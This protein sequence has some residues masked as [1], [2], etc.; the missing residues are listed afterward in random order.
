VA[1]EERGLGKEAVAFFTFAADAVSNAAW[2]RALATEGDALSFG[3]D[4]ALLPVVRA[5][6]EV[7]FAAG[8]LEWPVAGALAGVVV[9]E[10][11]WVATVPMASLSSPNSFHSSTCSR[12]WNRVSIELTCLVCSL[13]AQVR[14]YLYESL[15]AAVG[16][17]SHA[18]STNWYS[19]Q[20]QTPP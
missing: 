2:R 12:S 10:V 15:K 5:A 19:P 4:E 3:V 13:I 7:G 18:T 16:H 8:V 14:R 9:I 20:A 6:S 17:A 1:V 11:D